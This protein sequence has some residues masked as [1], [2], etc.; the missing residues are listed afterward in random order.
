MAKQTNSRYGVVF[1]ETL[2]EAKDDIDNLKLKARSVDRLNIVIETEAD[3]DDVELN[4]IGKLF[5]GK[6]WQA[7]HE[8]RVHEGWYIDRH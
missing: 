7:I 5:A 6:A 2:A 8:R 1:Y 3:M 4:R